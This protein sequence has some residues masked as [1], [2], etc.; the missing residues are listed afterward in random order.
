MKQQFDVLISGGGIIGLTA[1]L[2]MA[3]RHFH[4]GLVDAGNLEVNLKQPDL[5]VYALNQASQQLLQQVDAWQHVDT[6]RLS[7]Y[8]HMHVWD[9]QNKAAID[10]DCRMIAADRLGMICE[11]SVLKQALL[12]EIQKNERIH[13]FAHSRLMPLS[14]KAKK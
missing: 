7:P 2:A 6:T 5:R 12:K 13:L 11:E 1:A 14:I 8:T 4:V 3:Q 10:F 9:G